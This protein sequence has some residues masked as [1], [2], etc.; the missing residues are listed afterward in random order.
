M[1][2]KRKPKTSKQL[3]R[4]F[5]LSSGEDLLGPKVRGRSRNIIKARIAKRQIAF[6]RKSAGAKRTKVGQ[7]L[8]RAG[9]P[10]TVSAKDV[11]IVREPLKTAKTKIKNRNIQT[12]RR[13]TVH[14]KRASLFRVSAEG[15]LRARAKQ[16]EIKTLV[17][18]PRARKMRIGVT[19]P[20]A[21]PPKTMPQSVQD[22]FLGSRAIRR[23]A[24]DNR[25]RTLEVVFTT[26]Y[27]YQFFEVPYN[28]WINFQMAQSK[29]RFFMNQIY[30]HWTGPKG[31]M[32]YHPNYQYK[33]IF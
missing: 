20:F 29:G 16:I 9:V 25:T 27:G 2:K 30:G 12:K 7:S 31:S 18:S 5:G 24:Y 28:V 6:K 23:M 4:E 8:K 13:H 14:M 1:A 22:Y 19:D 11:T 3:I 21:Q 33:R 17:I 26:G 15:Q 10:F 32:T